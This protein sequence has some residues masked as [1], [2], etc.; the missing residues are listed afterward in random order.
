MLLEDFVGGSP[1][2]VLDVDDLRCCDVVERMSAQGMEIDVLGNESAGAFNI[3]D[4]EAAE[5][6]NVALQPRGKV[7][8]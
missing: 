7:G 8:T 4:R 2:A 1:D 3:I 6:F 5:R